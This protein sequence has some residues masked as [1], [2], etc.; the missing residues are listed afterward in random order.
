MTSSP[1]GA[2]GLLHVTDH[3]MAIFELQRHAERNVRG[4]VFA[5]ALG[6]LGT[7]VGRNGFEAALVRA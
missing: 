7:Y 1:P 3:Q 4:E 6:E 2:D 5:V